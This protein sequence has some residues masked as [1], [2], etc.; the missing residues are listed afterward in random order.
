MI[1]LLSSREQ[2][3]LYLIA[4][5]NT[6]QDIANRLHISC[7]TAITHRKNL[8]EKLAVRNTAGLVR[9]AFELGLLTAHQAVCP[10]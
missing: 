5:E 4:F 6:N 9:R 8:L 10:V 2:Q 3:V 1:P 7:H